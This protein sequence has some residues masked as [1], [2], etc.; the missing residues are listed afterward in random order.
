[1]L[2]SICF[3][4]K[5]RNVCFIL[6]VSSLHAL[7]ESVSSTSFEGSTFI[8]PAQ[9][10][11]FATGNLYSESRRDFQRH[12]D[13]ENFL[14]RILTYHSFFWLSF[15]SLVLSFFISQRNYC[16][17]K[18]CFWLSKITCGRRILPRLEILH[19]P[20]WFLLRPSY[21]LLKTFVETYETSSRWIL[22]FNIAMILQCCL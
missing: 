17:G 10:V 8:G 21:A 2:C 19:L 7:R 18:A 4:L 11:L 14:L 16:N 20:F 22:F 13:F 6:L 15:V 9:P 5:C 3:S 12:F 1:M